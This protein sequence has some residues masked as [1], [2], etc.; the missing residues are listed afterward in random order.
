MKA[1]VWC[2]SLFSTGN[3]ITTCKFYK[4]LEDEVLNNASCQGLTSL[5]MYMVRGFVVST[6]GGV[7]G[8]LQLFFHKL[9]R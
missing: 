7:N 2:L 5:M 3:N 8:H 1:S 4:E 9:T 6:K